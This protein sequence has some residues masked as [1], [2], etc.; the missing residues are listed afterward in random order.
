MKITADELIAAIRAR[1]SDA[2]DLRDAA[3]EAHHAILHVKRGPWTRAA[4]D[5]AVQT[6]YRKSFSYSFKLCEE[7]DARAVEQVVCAD[8]GVACWTV[9]HAAMVM[10][11]ECIKIDRVAGLELDQIVT[12]VRRRMVAPAIRKHAD[13]VIALASQPIVKPRRRKHATQIASDE[14]A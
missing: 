8:L 4:I 7:I 9:K 10:I 1:G 3:H 5:K 2:R 13:A 6:A 12:S 11:M 14:G